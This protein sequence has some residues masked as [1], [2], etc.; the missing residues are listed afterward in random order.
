VSGDKL[1]PEGERRA[2]PNSDRRRDRW[3]ITPGLGVIFA[4][5]CALSAIGLAQ[6]D[7]LSN[8]VRE[9]ALRTCELQVQSARATLDLGAIIE[10]ARAQ[11][12]TDPRIPKASADYLRQVKSLPA[13][14]PTT[15]ALQ[16]LAVLVA[17]SGM[18]P[19]PPH[20]SGPVAT[21]P[22]RLD[23]SE[24]AKREDDFLKLTRSLRKPRDC[25]KEFGK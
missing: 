3:R 15:R 9:G 2:H 12:S 24:L 21:P 7:H 1:P 13:S 18:A 10:A 5:V 25:N 8:R 14:E 19:S 23:V 11:T 17:G 20:D 16:D 6:Y 4:L 22:Q